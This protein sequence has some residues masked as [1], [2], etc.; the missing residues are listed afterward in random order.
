[1]KG[2]ILKRAFIDTLPVL[3][4]YMVLGIGFGIVLERNGY[5]VMWA[6]LMS[7]LIY[8]G[9]MQY[10]G[11]ELLA[12]AASLPAVALTTLMV[13]ARHLFLRHFNDR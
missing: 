6:F 5:G 13:N 3:S 11:I 4:G 9:S 12:G 2:K 7:L 1:M 10:A 8:A